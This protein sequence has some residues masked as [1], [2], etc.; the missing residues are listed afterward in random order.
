VNTF[1]HLLLFFIII[2][3]KVYG[4]ARPAAVVKALLNSGDCAI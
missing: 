4:P 3:F 1:A 2:V